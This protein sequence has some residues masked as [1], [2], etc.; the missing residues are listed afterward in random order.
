LEL[1]SLWQEAAALPASSTRM[2]VLVCLDS[3]LLT[4]HYSLLAAGG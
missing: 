2:T 4:I 3:S 1:V